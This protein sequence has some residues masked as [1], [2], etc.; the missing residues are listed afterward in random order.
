M[1]RLLIGLSA[2]T[3]VAAPLRA[4]GLRDKLSGLFIFGPGE[5]P[6]F[7][8]GSGD[9]N[10]PASLRVHGTH[11]VPAASSGNATIIA[12]LTDAISGNVA[13][14]PASATSSGSTFRFEGGVP[15]RTSLSPGPVFGERAQTLG[16]GRVLVGANRSQIDFSTLRGVDLHDI[17]LTF[18]HANVDFPGCDSASNGDCSLMGIPA[19]ENDIMQ[20]HLSLDV[21]LAVTSF[22]VTYGLLDHLDVGLVLPIVHTSLRGESEAQIVPFGGPTV[23]HYFGGSPENPVLT[24]SR[25]EEGTATGLGDVAVR[26][27]LS[28]RERGPV[29]VAV[30]GDVRFPTGSED[31]LL[32]SGE[33]EAR[34]LGILSARFG[35]FSPHV[36]L[37]YLY[38]AGRFQDDAVLATV[39]FDHLMAPWA[40]LA[41]DLIS[42]LQVGSSKLPIPGIVTIQAPFRRT[43]EPTSIPDRR[44]DIVNASFGMKFST[45]AGV[46]L[47]G[48]AI[49]PLNRGGLRPDMLWTVGLEYNF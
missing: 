49:W 44:D 28:A 29:A 6:L 26:V 13:Q 35:D 16:R 40:T 39:G 33:L 43:I 22:F 32:G 12:F 38:R 15:V 45:T 34:G 25:L 3:V 30:L 27:K 19:V 11:F 21:D 41:A 14:A 23:S 17:R 7:L 18:T 36:N 1:R 31:D 20:F 8:A 47:V 2:L 42:E 5:D 46:T 37:G 48:N 24:A 10:N 9:P 4:Q